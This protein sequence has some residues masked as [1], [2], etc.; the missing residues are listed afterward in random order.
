MNLFVIG[1]NLPKER[2]PIAVAELRQM[3]EVFPQLDRETLWHR[4][5]PCGTTFTASMHTADQAAASRRY[6]AQ[7][8][9]QVVFYS[10]LPV[11]PAGVYS[12]HRAEALSA[13]WDRLTENLEGQYFIV[14]AANDPLHLEL[15]TDILGIEQAFYLHQGD[16]WLVSNR[17]L[18]IERISKPSPLDPLGVS[19][20]LSIGWLGADRTL[21]RDIRVIPGGQ[22]WTWQ[23]GDIEPRRQS[24]F[25]LSRLARQPHQALT[26]PY[27]ERL[28]DDLMQLCRSLNQGFGELM[29]PLTGGRDTRLLAALLIHAGLPAQYY[30]AGDPSSADVEIGTLV[31]KTCNLP[32]RV[33]TIRASDVVKKWDEICWQYV[34]Q[35]DG[36]S[37]LW[38]IAD[39]LNMASQIERLDLSLWGIGGEIARGYYSE[40][41]LFL[42]RHDLA[43][44]QRFLAE[45]GI[46]DYGGLIRQEGSAMARD[47]VY[48]FVMQCID[49]GFAPVDVPDVFYTYQRVGRWGG[50]NARRVMPIG[51]L[52]SPYCSRPFV[53]AAFAMSALQ[54]YT[55]P[56]HYNLTRLLAPVLHGLPCDKGPWRL[57]QPA[58]NLL[59]LYGASMLRNARRRIPSAL[60]RTLRHLKPKKSSKRSPTFDR[61]GWF[62]AKREQVREI[63]LDQDNSLLW[64]FVDRSMFE[65][66]MSPTTDPAE[67]SRHKAVLYNIATLFYYEADHQRHVVP[68]AAPR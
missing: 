62:E 8:D 24:Y 68:A 3:L 25:A 66:I 17:V 1:W 18:L 16:M 14:R 13:H 30:T 50:N 28:A 48:R 58:M 57:Q 23:E 41:R 39:V 20:F 35:N 7:S 21:R 65:R 56:L 63:C 46:N 4:S 2:H 10:G 55:Q 19:L 32:H 38:Q 26:P 40:P 64:S 29:C 61:S 15:M 51:D 27:L 45:K 49:E 44:A 53:E 9:D 5:S 42:G 59:Y 52:F 37:S 22:V 43:G 34:R 54:R 12:A 36:M 67:R 33:I 60:R 6:V 11:D 31:A 47:Y